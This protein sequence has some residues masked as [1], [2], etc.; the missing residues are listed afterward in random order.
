MFTITEDDADVNPFVEAFCHQIEQNKHMDFLEVLTDTNSQLTS[1]GHE[2]V[3]LFSTLRKL[4]P[5]NNISGRKGKY[6]SL[7]AHPDAHPHRF[8]KPLSKVQYLCQE[9]L[10]VKVIIFNHTEFLVNRTVYRQ[11]DRPFHF[12]VQFEDCMRI[13]LG[14]YADI[15]HITENNK[16]SALNVLDYMTKGEYGTL[17]E[18]ISTFTCLVQLPT[19][20]T[21]I[22]D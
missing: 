1:S 11:M 17:F 2:A 9:N 14:D 19:M 6:T 12:G 5:M 8:K 18:L 21:L 16:L 22:L 10:K 13:V 20:V 15:K 7:I 4:I 3:F